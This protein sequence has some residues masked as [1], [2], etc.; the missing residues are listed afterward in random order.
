MPALGR[1]RQRSSIKDLAEEQL[2]D[3]PTS[4]LDPEMV[5]E[6][7][8]T[9][10]ALAEE[11]MTMICVRAHHRQPGARARSCSDSRGTQSGKDLEPRPASLLLAAEHPGGLEPRRSPRRHICSQQRCCDQQQRRPGECRRI[12]RIDLEQHS[13]HQ[14]RRNHCP[15]EA[16]GCANARQTQRLG[17]HEIAYIGSCGAES[18]SNSDLAVALTNVRRDYRAESDCRQE[19]RC[20]REDPDKPRIEPWSCEWRVQE[21]AEWCNTDDLRV[22]STARTCSCDSDAITFSDAVCARRASA[23]YSRIAS[24]E[25]ECRARRRQL[26]VARRLGYTTTVRH[27]SSESGPPIFRRFP[28]GS[29]P[30]HVCV[31]TSSLTMA[32]FNAPSRSASVNDRP[33]GSESGRFRSSWR[34]PIRGSAMDSPPHRL[35]PVPQRQTSARPTR[36]GSRTAARYRRCRRNPWRRLEPHNE[37]VENT[38]VVCRSKNFELGARSMS[39]R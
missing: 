8:D 10:V 29:S 26:A 30:G 19:Q 32:T 14:P 6:V 38:R 16:S 11:G 18:N 31:A 7:L 28:I 21:V 2:F 4:A 27:G 36:R 37:L 17:Q 34:E 23:P 33:R 22:G 20:D 3:E 13:T 24:P 39:T 35:R 9:M 25:V 1:P 15:D 5:K 12:K